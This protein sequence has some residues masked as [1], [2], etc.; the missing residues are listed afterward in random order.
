[1]WFASGTWTGSGRRLNAFL[2]VLLDRSSGCLVLLMLA[3]IA[4][5]FC[6]LDLPVWISAGVWGTAAGILLVSALLP[7]IGA[8]LEQGGQQ[9]P[10]FELK[11]AKPLTPVSGWR[12][13]ILRLRSSMIEAMRLYLQRPGLLF[14]TTLL[15]VVVQGANVV[16]VWFIGQAIHAPIPDPD[17]WILV[18]WSR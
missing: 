5:V 14:S 6:P 18:L 12:N 8:W 13:S 9:T 1:M 15:S 3:C 16:V 10:Q 11:I 2:S 17:Y 7:L 4:V